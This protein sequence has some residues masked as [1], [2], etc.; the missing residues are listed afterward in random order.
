MQFDKAKVTK[1]HLLRNARNH[2][3]DVRDVYFTVIKKSHLH[4]KKLFNI[5]ERVIIT[6]VKAGNTTLVK[7][8]K[9]FDYRHRSRHSAFHVEVQIV[10]F[11]T[12]YLTSKTGVTFLSFSNRNR[13]GLYDCFVLHIVLNL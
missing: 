3:K 8:V 2:N 7:N 12:F 1:L 13:R 11:F 4:I 9:N 5:F 10:L 6:L